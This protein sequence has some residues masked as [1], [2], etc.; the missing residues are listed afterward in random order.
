MVDLIVE[1]L[2]TFLWG[3]TSA[4]LW[5]MDESYNL[6]MSVATLNFADVDLLW[7]Y[8]GQL[9][10]GMGFFVVMRFSSIFI[11][12]MFNEEFREKIEGIDLIKKFALIGL[13]LT[14]SPFAIKYV[15]SISINAIENVGAFT[16]STNTI[17][18]SSLIV[19]SYLNKDNGSFDENGKWIEKGVIHYA[20]GDIKINDDDPS[21]K[22]DYKFFPEIQ[23]IFIIAIIGIAAAILF[24]MNSVQIAKRAFSL[25]LKTLVAPIPISSL[26]NPSDDSFATWVKM[27]I[28]DVVTNFFQVFFLIVILTFI[29]SSY[30]KNL[31]VWVQLISLIAGLL[32]L[33]SGIPEITRLIGGDTS[34]G[35][36]LQQ[37]SQLRMATR[38]MGAAV[39]GGVGAVAGAIGGSALTAGAGGVYGAGRMLGGDK[40]PPSSGSNA[41]SGKGRGGDGFQSGAQ[42]TADHGPIKTSTSPNNPT[43][44]GEASGQGA[45]S[46]T[47]GE[48]TSSSYNSSDSAYG[49]SGGLAGGSSPAFNQ[50]G[51]NLGDHNKINT[52][53][54]RDSFSQRFSARAN[55]AEGFKGVAARF[56]SNASAHTYQASM[57]RL[58]KSRPIRAANTFT[59]LTQ[60][61]ED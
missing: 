8:W 36:V 19:T 60:R 24:L 32:I 7:K 16:G 26:I 44:S 49:A 48:S 57:Q 33:V 31:G 18:P 23:D 20:L 58:N 9:M 42:A 37:L 10:L 15:T 61:K 3:L 53:Q 21:G 29:S 27:I 2:R 6:V 40:L 28:A 54:T 12:S 41:G 50:G 11:R 34:S 1:G 46:P 59:S 25:A 45:S 39:A 47:Q 52:S 4:L 14:F 38:G 35:G 13:C 56:T 30:V 17:I 43:S 55:E 51:K 22:Y 5:M